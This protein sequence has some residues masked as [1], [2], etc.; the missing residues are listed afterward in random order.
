MKAVRMEKNSV[1]VEKVV[2]S[3]CIVAE[4]VLNEGLRRIREGDNLPDTPTKL[5]IEVCNDFEE[6]IQ[7]V[8]E[9]ADE[10]SEA[11]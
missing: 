2:K 3:F 8:M 6:V 7:K 9:D 5:L 4:E 10:K 11:S 1:A